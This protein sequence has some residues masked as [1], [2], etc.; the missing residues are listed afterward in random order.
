MLNHMGQKGHLRVLVLA[1]AALAAAGCSTFGGGSGGTGLREILQMRQS[2]ATP[3]SVDAARLLAFYELRNFNPAWTG[4]AEAEQLAA[5]AR[6]MLA[7]AEEHGLRSKDYAVAAS[8]GTLDDEL[9]LSGAVLRYGHDLREGR[10]KP[11]D[12]YMDAELPAQR[13]DAAAA[14]QRA[15]R[16]R[17]LGA[18]VAA[19][20]PPHAEYQ[21]LLA[22]LTRYRKVAEGEGWGTLRVGDNL[23]NATQRKLLAERLALEDPAVAALR[24]PT[25]AQLRE[26]LKRFQTRTGLDA[27][28]HIGPN[29]LA[30]L[31][32]PATRRVEQ[33]E[34]NLERWR[35]LPRQFE[36]RY[37]MVDVPA[38]S[39]RFV[40]EGEAVL[41]SRVI[42]GRETTPTPILKTT[43][44]AIVAS[45]PWNIPGDVSA[46]DLLPEL[47]KNPNY[48]AT[49]N[50]VWLDA[51]KGDP[52]G[53]KVDWK[54]VTPQEMSWR[55]IRQLPGPDSG[56]GELMLDMPNTF[57]V[58]LHDTPG[59][60]L[61]AEK[62]R[63]I[64]N[65]CIRVEKIFALASLALTNDAEAGLPQLKEV[66]KTRQTQRL[67]LKEPLPVYMVYWTVAAAEDGTVEFRPDPYERDKQLLAVRD[68]TLE[69]RRLTLN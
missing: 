60:E 24:A 52:S 48:L 22:A 59:K 65:G 18:Y 49:R 11:Q 35:W 8:A 44:A 40:H 54:K 57:D 41:T 53:K 20:A 61:F 29:T 28:G 37:V 6:A 13:F 32:V 1:V 56:L 17:E 14:L 19:L 23:E 34:A 21:R 39:V 7:R 64:S 45:P 51:P 5:E 62:E 47:K 46:R 69:L 43:V 4:S 15:V 33:I 2:A 3:E 38:Q 67:A 9:A 16:T 27:D 68:G 66:T 36:R 58:Y 25:V 30:A 12:V 50:M 26:A 10:L 55:R 63:T 42:V 31:N